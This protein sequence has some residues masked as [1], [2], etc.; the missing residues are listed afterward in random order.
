MSRCA[1][2]C[3]GEICHMLRCDVTCDGVMMMM[4]MVLMI[5]T[6]MMRMTIRMSMMRMLMRMMMATMM[7]RMMMMRL[8]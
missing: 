2:T 4:R 3:Y 1:F 7:M 8:G 5:M 6:R